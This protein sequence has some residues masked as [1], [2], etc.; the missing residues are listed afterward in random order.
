MQNLFPKKLLIILELQSETQMELVLVVY[1]FML[2]FSNEACNCCLKYYKS[3]MTKDERM[4][5][6]GRINGVTCVCFTFC[7]TFPKHKEGKLMANAC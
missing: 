7:I 2:S 1:N 4:K 6:G 3:N 5:D